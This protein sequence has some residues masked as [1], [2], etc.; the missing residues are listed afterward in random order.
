[1]QE[2]GTIQYM[3]RFDGEKGI[4]KIKHNTNSGQDKADVDTWLVVRKQLTNASQVCIHT[5]AH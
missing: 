2:T 4:I 5:R 3:R 1:M